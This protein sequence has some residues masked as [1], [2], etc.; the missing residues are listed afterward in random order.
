MIK[1][2]QNLEQ[3]DETCLGASSS[4]AVLHAVA[5]DRNRSYA[6]GGRWPI[7]WRK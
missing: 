1:T 7:S 2:G 4:T 6:L 3:W 5:R